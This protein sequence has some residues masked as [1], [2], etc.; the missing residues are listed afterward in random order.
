VRSEALAFNL[1]LVLCHVLV[2]GDGF[3]G[4]SLTWLI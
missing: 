1:R 2:A 3:K 4:E